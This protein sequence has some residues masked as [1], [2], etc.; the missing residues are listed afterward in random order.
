MVNNKL[1]EILR[2]QKSLSEWKDGIVINKVSAT[3]K[4]LDKQKGS[5]YNCN[6]KNDDRKK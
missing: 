1:H 5:G 4:S 3:H 6:I 2:M